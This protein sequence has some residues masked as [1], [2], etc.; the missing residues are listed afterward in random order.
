MRNFYIVYVIDCIASPF[1]GEDEA[2]RQ[3]YADITKVDSSVN[4]YRRL[5][6]MAGMVNASICETK[7]QAEKIR[8]LWNDQFKR[9]GTYMI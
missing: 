7:K 2:Y 1:F 3:H 4:L 6:N 9:Q 5:D 8:D